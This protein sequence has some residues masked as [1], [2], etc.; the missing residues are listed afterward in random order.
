[1]TPCF[2]FKS[3]F[4]LLLIGRAILCLS[5]WAGARR[6]S[7]ANSFDDFARDAARVPGRR[8]DAT[9]HKSSYKRSGTEIFPHAFHRQFTVVVAS[10]CAFSLFSGSP[11]CTTSFVKA[12][13]LAQ[14]AERYRLEPSAHLLF[15]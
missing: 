15:L 14:G 5:C 11:L 7:L 10:V 1:M 12:I 3:L 6:S 4:R 13:F 2:F 8:Q 9:L